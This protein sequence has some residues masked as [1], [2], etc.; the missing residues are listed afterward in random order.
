MLISL[1]TGLVAV[2]LFNLTFLV[3]K[4]YFVL[5]LAVVEEMTCVIINCC[6]TSTDDRLILNVINRMV[7]QVM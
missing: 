7:V 2:A 4:I 3:F 6:F 1:A 5:L